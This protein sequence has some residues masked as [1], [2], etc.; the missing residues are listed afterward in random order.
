MVKKLACFMIILGPV[1][2][3]AQGAN[4][5]TTTQTPSTTLAPSASAYP[6]AGQSYD[7]TLDQVRDRLR[8]TPQQQG[9]WRAY[10]GKVDAY[11]GLYYREK[12]VL[13]TEEDSAARQV[14]RLVDKLQNRLAALEDVERAA[15]DLYSSLSSEQQ[16][17]A[18][19]MLLSTIPTF[20]SS[21]TASTQPKSDARR[22]GDKAEN[23][24]RTRRPGGGMG[25]GSF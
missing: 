9:L 1:A 20:E 3:W 18:N 11:T 25:G 21:V 22:K 2:C 6:T 12:P 14:G 24:M 10:E 8:L 16:K 13:A 19:Q 5:A 23:A 17:T 15:K 4:E 7:S